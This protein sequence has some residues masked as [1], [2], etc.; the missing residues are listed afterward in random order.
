MLN[1][2]SA[3]DNASI[4][5]CPLYQNL[6]L[7]VEVVLCT[8][9]RAR[10]PWEAQGN[11]TTTPL[12]YRLGKCQEHLLSYTAISLQKPVFF[13]WQF[14]AFTCCI[15]A[16]NIQCHSTP[17]PNQTVW[18][19]YRFATSI[20]STTSLPSIT[21][22]EALDLPPIYSTTPLCVEGATGYASKLLNTMQGP[23]PQWNSTMA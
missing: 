18:K 10:I 12:V 8:K 1:S 4:I 6:S 14:D 16:T 22:L 17:S 19:G 5:T 21:T 2:P 23:V 13:F 3:S 20:Q 9:W 15:F 7:R 11:M